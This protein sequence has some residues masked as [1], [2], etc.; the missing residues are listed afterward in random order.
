MVALP[1]SPP[2]PAIIPAAAGAALTGER[3][4]ISPAGLSSFR[5]GLAAPLAMAEIELADGSTAMGV[6]CIEPTAPDARDIT[7]FGDW[8]AY[9]RY[10][11]ATRP[12]SG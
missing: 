4:T 2:E 5:S 8:R 7:E 11:T 6:H 1:A 9:L 3:W 12:M 10:L